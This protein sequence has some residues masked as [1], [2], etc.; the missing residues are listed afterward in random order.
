[1]HSPSAAASDQFER[2]SLSH[3][4]LAGVVI[5]LC[6][7]FLLP[8]EADWETLFEFQTVAGLIGAAVVF[9][10]LYRFWPAERS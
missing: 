10:L 5:G 7:I 8:P 1:M 6:L 2:P 3:R 9:C 4:S